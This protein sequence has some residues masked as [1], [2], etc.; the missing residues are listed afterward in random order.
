M[1]LA[2]FH[3]DLRSAERRLYHLE[4]RGREVDERNIEAL[5]TTEILQN[6]KETLLT[7]VSLL[8]HR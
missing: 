4:K 6:E 7:W 3:S 5:Q 8:V 1:E 2:Q